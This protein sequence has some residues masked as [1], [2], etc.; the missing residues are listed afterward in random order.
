M[1]TGLWT[2]AGVSFLAATIFPAQSELLLGVMQRQGVYSAPVLLATA[3][4]GNI[5]G[6]CLNWL[7][8]RGVARF[9]NKRYFPV[10]EKQLTRAC[11]AFTKYGVWTLL[12]AWVPFIGDPI[13]VA[14]GVLRVRFFVF[15]LYV[16]IGK[17]ARYALL[18]WAIQP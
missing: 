8:G 13:T 6:S 15:F 18:L 7:L 10:S 16:S 12:F 1:L 9:R 3:S 2:L 17:I 11:A 5:A 4:T 14:S